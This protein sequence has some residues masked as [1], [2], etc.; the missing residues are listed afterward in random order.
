MGKD[1]RVPYYGSLGSDKDTES[2]HSDD[3]RQ[4]GLVSAVFI[5]LNRMIGTGVFATPSTILSLSGSVG[6]S[7]VM[8]VVGS[9][10]AA[11][12][13]WVYIVWG[14]AI[15][16]NGGEKN[17][18]EYLFR[19]PKFL[20]TCAYAANGVLLGWASGNSI[21]FGEYILRALNHSPDQ[22][23]RR[24]VAFMAITFCFLLHGTRVRWGLYLQN[25]LGMLKIG[26]LL[27][28]VVTGFFAFGGHLKVDKPDN[29]TNAFEGTTASASS[30]C[31]S[32]YNVIWSFVGYHNANFAL[33]EV[34]NPKRTIRIA[35]PLAI[36]LVTVLYILANIAYFAAA[37]KEEI[38]GSGT[39]VASLLFHN[40]YGDKAARFL[41]IFVALSALGNVLS[42]IFAQGRVNQ[43]LGR[44]GVLPFSRL[45]ASNKPLD[46]PLA[47]LALHWAVCLITILAL[48]P[49]DAYNFVIN[50]IS[51]PLAVINA[52]IAFGIVYLHFR[53]YA[54][55]KTPGWPAVV[56][57]AFFGA[58]NVFLLV[59]PFTPP[60]PGGEPYATM[61]Y[62]T[63]AVAGWAIFGIGFIYWLVWAQV[64]PRVG[65]YTLV[66]QN[67]VGGD[68]LAR[69]V[70]RQVK[71]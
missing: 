17:Y 1:K 56:A 37:S 41:D 50:T 14:T 35:G 29:F 33:S 6:M 42:V 68:G 66:R 53:P 70:F 22:W 32:L 4:I 28:V 19:K 16:R 30:F 40:V 2:L 12:G 26:I 65:G 52:T 44:E 58:A 48:P 10:I 49:G 34:K 57:A 61:P 13:M 31:L 36:G 5:I 20:A 54:D 69:N 24:I 47:G 3:R 64:L 67:E 9:I 46:A 23:T 11:A 18:L 38:T 15:P 25:V 43:E 60:P 45:W 51:Y 55:W 39:L 62:Y 59:V 7:L 27:V 71:N 8:W 63:H 21:V